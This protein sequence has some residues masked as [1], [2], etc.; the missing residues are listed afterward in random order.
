MTMIPFR[1]PL[2]PAFT[3]P[4]RPGGIAFHFQAPVSWARRSYHLAIACSLGSLQLRP[5]RR[6]AK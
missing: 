2:H 4:R 1:H 6:L 3:G 5:G